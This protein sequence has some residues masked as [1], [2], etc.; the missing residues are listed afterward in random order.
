MCY[1]KHSTNRVQCNVYCISNVNA[2]VLTVQV[3]CK[4]EKCVI[5]KCKT[6]CWREI[7]SQTEKKHSSVHLSP[8]VIEII[9]A[10]SGLYIR[11][12]HNLIY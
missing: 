8:K 9:I 4:T 7:A 12:P 10:G 6:N 3:Y 5:I 11:M 2:A 1:K